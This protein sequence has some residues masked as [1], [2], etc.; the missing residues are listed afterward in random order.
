MSRLLW[1]KRWIV[2]PNA[3]YD[4]VYAILRVDMANP[5]EAPAEEA[6][7]VIKVVRSQETAEN[8]VRRLNKLNEAKNYLYFWQVTRLER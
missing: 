1:P 7:Y 4:H 2:Q 3:K 8:E 6:I 5:P